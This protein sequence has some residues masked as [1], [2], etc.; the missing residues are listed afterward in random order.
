MPSHIAGA[1]R[2]GAR[3]NGYG[4]IADY[5]KNMAVLEALTV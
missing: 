5:T 2:E 1:L 3:L 4:D